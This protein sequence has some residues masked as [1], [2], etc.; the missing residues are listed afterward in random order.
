[1][2]TPNV[3]AAATPANE[4][5]ASASPTKAMPRTTTNAP[6]TALTTPTNATA[7]SARCMNSNSSG[8][9]NQAQTPMVSNA[10]PSVMAVM[11]HV[12][13]TLRR[14]KE[15]MLRVCLAQDLGRDRLIGRAERDEAA[16]Q[17][18]RQVE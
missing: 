10:E 7:S 18:Q 11:V 16:V 12:Q 5:C 8:S 13:T 4:A 1:M 9:A 2:D 14:Q 15:E 3:K 17:E 6:T